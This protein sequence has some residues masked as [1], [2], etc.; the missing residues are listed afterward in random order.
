MKWFSA[1][2]IGFI[3][4]KQSEKKNKDEACGKR[5]RV[6]QHK[7]KST[8]IR[9]LEF[10]AGGRPRRRGDTVWVRSVKGGDRA[11]F[12]HEKCKRPNKFFDKDGPIMQPPVLPV[13]DG[14]DIAG[15]G[16]QDERPLIR[17][18]SYFGPMA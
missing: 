12:N 7:K 15:D 18:V 3:C 5:C 10:F 11:F 14:G 1:D 9:I 4:R 16:E 6:F 13:D 2:K 17:E 8:S